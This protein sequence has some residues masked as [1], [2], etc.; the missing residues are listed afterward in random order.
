MKLVHQIVAGILAVIT[1]FTVWVTAYK[2]GVASLTYGWLGIA[3]GGAVQWTYL[4][5]AFRPHKR[6][7][8]AAWM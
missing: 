5:W 1:M 4:S 8:F 2:L 6:R 7:W 3:A